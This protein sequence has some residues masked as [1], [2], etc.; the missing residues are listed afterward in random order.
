MFFTGI[1]KVVVNNIESANLSTWM[2]DRVNAEMK[3]AVT[4]VP[5]SEIFA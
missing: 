2:P 5:E 4:G 3:I 1:E